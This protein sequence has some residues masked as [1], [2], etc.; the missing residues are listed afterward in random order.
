MKR[1]L[2]RSVLIGITCAVLEFASPVSAAERTRPTRYQPQPGDFTLV[3]TLFK[4]PAPGSSLQA[5]VVPITYDPRFQIGARIER[6]TR[7]IAPW[8]VGQIVTF[9][10]HSPS[11]LLPGN[12]AGQ[13]FVLT[14][15]HFRP[16]T[17]NDKVWFEVKTRYLLR[18]IERSAAPS[19]N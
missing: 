14:F 18:W 13:Q 17:E 7:G 2:G 1:Y 8:R 12:F 5:P 3:C 16:T 11:L 9:V 15:S 6:V 4:G 19:P 10:I